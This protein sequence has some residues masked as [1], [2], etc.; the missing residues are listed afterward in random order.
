[1]PH[2]RRAVLGIFAALASG[3]ACGAGPEGDVASSA[4]LSVAPAHPASGP[5]TP[6]TPA[7]LIPTCGPI[8]V[9]AFNAADFPDA[10]KIDNRW[11][12]LVPG[13]QFV[14]E[15]Y[16][17]RD[18]A[19]LGRQIV[20]TVTDLTKV[21]NGVPAVVVWEVARNQN[22]V[23]RSELVFLAQDRDGN[24]WSLGQYPELYT[25]GRLTGAPETWLAGL[26]RASAGL[27]VRGEP[28]P[29][30][31]EF[32]QVAAPSA[33]LLDCAKDVRVDERTCV[34]NTCYDGVA[35]VDER[36]G[37][38]QAFGVQRRFYAP[39]VGSVRVEDVGDPTGET[40][41]LA[42]VVTLDPLAEATARKNVLDVEKRAYQ[43]DA[44]GGYRQTPPAT[45]RP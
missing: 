19:P 28:T 5:V 8:Q 15:A 10:T 20:V 30:S 31:A 41:L 3:T 36:S 17:N 21:I 39:G 7:V 29:G 25:N 11:L 33:E 44:T 40:L 26:S 32:L 34:A 16:A 9:P 38:G 23:T 42:R 35:V 14:F 13:T 27:V 18:G 12:P 1:M 45:L 22:A 6:V 2:L 43:S 37:R 24:V 4:P